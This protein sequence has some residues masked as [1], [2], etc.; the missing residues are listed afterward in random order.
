MSPFSKMESRDSSCRRP[1]RPGSLFFPVTLLP[2]C[3]WR[4]WRLGG[5]FFFRAAAT[6]RQIDRLV[7]E[8]YGSTE[9]GQATFPTSFGT[10]WRQT[11]IS[12]QARRPFPDP[13]C[14]NLSESAGTAV[15]VP[16]IACRSW[17]PWRLGGFI[18]VSIPLIFLSALWREARHV[19]S[20]SAAVNVVAVP[21]DYFLCV[22]VPLWQTA[23]FGS[24][25]H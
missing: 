17:R 23:R 4:S 13:I 8:L 19:P 24:E 25:L 14:E 12:Q 16:L 6:D 10:V 18:A 3:S 1:L 7:Y 15:A 11:F 20:A 2:C 21:P 22:S 5:L 9:R